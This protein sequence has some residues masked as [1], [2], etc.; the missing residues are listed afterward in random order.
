MA[1]T[2]TV[3]RESVPERE[4]AAFDAFVADCENDC[5]FT[6]KDAYDVQ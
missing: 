2:P 1:R 5:Q 6:V 3:T 4:R